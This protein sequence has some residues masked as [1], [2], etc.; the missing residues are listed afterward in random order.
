[1]PDED[2]D[3]AHR[4]TGLA[5]LHQMHHRK[6]RVAVF[7]DLGALVAVARILDRQVV[8][9]EFF[10]HRIEFTIGRIAQRHPDEA[11]LPFKVIADLLDGKV[12]K[13]D[14]VLVGNAID[15]HG[16]SPSVYE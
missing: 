9:P 3:L 4:Q 5:G 7:L 2:A 6:Q 16:G 15:Q 1:M 10:L 12:G 11:I 14:A 13:L 8:Q